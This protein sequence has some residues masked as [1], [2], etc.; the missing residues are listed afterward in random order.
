MKID[1]YKPSVGRIT[2]NTILERKTKYRVVKNPKFEGWWHV[3]YMEHAIRRR[4]KYLQANDN[5]G[6][7]VFKS[8]RMAT[9]YCER[10]SKKRNKKSLLDDKLIKS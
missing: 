3:Q 6:V 10:M 2:N 5:T 1:I 8:E 7:R 4:W 9:R